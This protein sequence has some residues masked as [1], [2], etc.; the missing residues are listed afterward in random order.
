MKAHF[1]ALL[2]AAALG[3]SAC[4]TTRPEGDSE[5]KRP[6]KI[7]SSEIPQAEAPEGQGSDPAVTE[8]PQ[9]SEPEETVGPVPSEPKGVVLVFGPGAA[10]GFAHAGVLRALA[11]ARIRVAAVLG[12]ETGALIGALGASKDTINAFEWSLQKIK[13]DALDSNP[14]LLKALFGEG[15]TGR[16]LK[17]T[18]KDLFS[19]RKL[20]SLRY[21]VLVGFSDERATSWASRGEVADLIA[22]SFGM[23]ALANPYPVQEARQLGLGPVVVVDVIAHDQNE[24]PTLPDGDSRAR[25]KSL[26]DT[27]KESL[28]E[29]GEADLVIRPDLR[30]VGYQDYS[31][32]N[33]AIFKGKQAVQEMI[34]NG[35]L[36]DLL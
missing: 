29:I 30:N 33:E 18:L 21:P 22:K 13:N 6:G 10:R 15:A 20:E 24:I 19:N 4:A 2:T 35:S 3:A 26:R 16:K 1:I 14:S 8:Q 23:P 28:D 25:F 17:G 11:D 27:R 5:P 32:R 9:A 34:Q 12:T 36:R 31:K 7:T